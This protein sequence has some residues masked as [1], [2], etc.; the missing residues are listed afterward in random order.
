MKSRIP[1]YIHISTPSDWIYIYRRQ[2]SRYIIKGITP[3]LL[4][5]WEDHIFY[6]EHGKRRALTL[7]K[8]GMAICTVMIDDHLMLYLVTCT[9]TGAGILLRHTMGHSPR[10]SR[11][12]TDH[13]LDKSQSTNAGSLTSP[14]G[15]VSDSDSHRQQ[16]PLPHA[17]LHS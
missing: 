14:S 12:I 1:V 9:V 15:R 17:A 8:E 11:V 6:R 5:L 3:P 10:V 16:K 4:F 2:I 7:K 13:K